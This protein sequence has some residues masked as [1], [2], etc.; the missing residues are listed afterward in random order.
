MISY[1]PNIRP[2]FLIQTS[3][4]FQ[5]PSPDFPHLQ[6]SKSFIQ[7]SKSTSKSIFVYS[8]SSSSTISTLPSLSSFS[9]SQYVKKLKTLEI[10]F[11]E[12]EFDFEE[13]PKILPY[14]F[15]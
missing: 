2:I 3:N 1:F 12:P 15:P 5:V 7:V 8:Q 14:I 4:S 11:I 6:P 13:V 9:T 10:A